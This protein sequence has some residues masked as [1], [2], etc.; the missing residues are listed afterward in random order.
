MILLL[1]GYLHFNLLSNP[2]NCCVDIDSTISSV[3]SLPHVCICGMAVRDASCGAV[4]YYAN[5]FA[6]FSTFLELGCCGVEVFE[7][8][9]NK[10]LKAREAVAAVRLCW[11]A[12]PRVAYSVGLRT[13][14]L[15][16]RR[17]E[18]EMQFFGVFAGCCFSFLILILV[19]VVCSIHPFAE[20]PRHCLA[21]SFP[22]PVPTVRLPGA[23]YWRGCRRIRV[24]A[25]FR[26]P[27]LLL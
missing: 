1:T 25:R 13:Q 8:S 26:V 6:C 27:I 9:W 17:C 24:L 12:H 14:I 22:R 20:K 3:L 4:R 10:Q 11:N 18:R 2:L 5:H 15:H 21:F 7:S 19:S 16:Q 23:F